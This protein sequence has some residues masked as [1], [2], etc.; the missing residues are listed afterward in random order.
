[1]KKHI[2][3]A[4]VAVFITTLFTGF[5]QPE[6]GR[7]QDNHHNDNVLEGIVLGAGALI[8][9]TAIAQSLNPRQTARVYAPPLSLQDLATGNSK[10]KEA[11]GK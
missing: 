1:M 4:A 3:L 5:A 11:T 10:E 9:G 7:H 2:A 6:P 8:L